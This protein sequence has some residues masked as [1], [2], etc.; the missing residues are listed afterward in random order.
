M[1]QPQAPSG[2]FFHNLLLFGRLLHELGLEAYPGR[3]LEVQEAVQLVGIA[4]RADFYF[5]LRACLVR[6]AEDLPRFDQAFD[7][8]WR[9]PRGEGWTFP[10]DDPLA[11]PRDEPPAPPPAVLPQADP[12]VHPAPDEDAADDREV[13]ELTRTYSARAQLRRKD[14]ADLT[15]AEYDAIRE[16]IAALT[17]QAGLRRTRRHTPG[18]DDLPDMRRSL[19]KSLQHGGE[20]LHWSYRTPKL[21]PRPVV[22]IADISGSMERYTRVL[23]HFM[24]GMLHSQTRRMDA[25]LFG[26]RLTYISRQLRAK[27]VDRALDDVAT[28]VRD[29]SGGTRTGESLRELNVHWAG[30]VLRGSPIVLLISDGW[31]RGDPALLHQEMGRLRRFSHRIIWLNPLL[32]SAQYEPLTRGMQAALP[33][34]DDFLPVHN[35]ASLEQLTDHLNRL[36]ARRTVRRRARPLPGAAFIGGRR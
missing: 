32:S 3:M 13:V 34:I 1:S 9:Q 8:F 35:L 14:F 23:L 5:T 22:I 33:W 25:F 19:R 6:R 28:A 24:Y 36:D 30:R 12:D 15:P 4:S 26:T 27:D 7:L 18:R 29:W 17:W 2:T 10:L 21:K 11:P 16:L 20:L 31:D